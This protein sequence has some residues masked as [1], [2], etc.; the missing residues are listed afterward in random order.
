MLIPRDATAP[1][2]IRIEEVFAVVGKGLNAVVVQDDN[3][4]DGVTPSLRVR[5]Q[6]E[7]DVL[8]QREIRDELSLQA[9]LLAELGC[10]LWSREVRETVTARAAWNW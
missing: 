7:F 5:L 9:I 2:G 4:R 3:S 1:E 6:W 10:V 8:A